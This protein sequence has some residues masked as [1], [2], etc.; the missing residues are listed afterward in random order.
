MKEL[1]HAKHAL[2]MVLSAS[3][4][5]NFMTPN[6]LSISQNTPVSEAA[7]FLARRGI[8]AAPVIDEAGRPVGVVS[9][10]DILIHMGQAAVYQVGAPRG[11]ARPES[12]AI[13]GD[14]SWAETANR[15]TVREIMTPGVFCVHPETPAAKVVEKMLALKVRRLFVVD[16]KDALIGVISA[17]D[18]LGQLRNDV[19]QDG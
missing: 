16:D 12:R 2:P 10:I 9:S 18:I 5:A 17:I 7:T 8:S 4:A 6:P 19:P 14:N 1:V 15:C 3:R 13:S 11:D